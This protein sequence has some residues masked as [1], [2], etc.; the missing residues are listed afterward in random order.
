MD[1]SRLVP[2]CELE[3]HG[4]GLIKTMHYEGEMYRVEAWFVNLNKM[5][6]NLLESEYFNPFHAKA[7]TSDFSTPKDKGL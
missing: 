5:S 7:L 2:N 4:H 1:S 3:M 6:W